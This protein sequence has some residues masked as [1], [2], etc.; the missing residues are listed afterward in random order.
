M[1]LEL[2]SF[3]KKKVC[4]D[5]IKK[6]LHTLENIESFYDKIKRFYIRKH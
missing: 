1:I 4:Y 3:Y 2:T 5:K 6:I